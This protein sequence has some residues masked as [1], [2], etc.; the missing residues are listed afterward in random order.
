MAKLASS[1]YVV[2][3]H[4]HQEERAA[5]NLCRQGFRVWLP[6]YMRSIRHARR[7]SSINAPVFP[8]YLFVHFDRDTTPWH[9]IRSTFG[10]RMIV[11]NDGR[12]TPV[13]PG[14]LSQIERQI[15]DWEAAPTTL[16]QLKPGDRLQVM[17]GTFAGLEGRF[18]ELSSQERVRLLLHALG[19]EVI[20]TMPPERLRLPDL[21]LAR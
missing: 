13:P 11:S 19:G 10:V 15:M 3:T 9:P 20:V 8:G 21:S 4:T 17:E 5:T 7:Q 1:W 16:A 6:T 14:I 12:P 18:L 2:N